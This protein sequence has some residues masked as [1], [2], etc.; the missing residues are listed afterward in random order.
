M[1]R[2]RQG[3]PIHIHYHWLFTEPHTH[4]ALEALQRIGTTPEVLAWL[5]SRLPIR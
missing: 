3:P 4:T 5:E 2:P 1:D